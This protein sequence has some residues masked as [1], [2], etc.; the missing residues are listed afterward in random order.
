ML[1]LAPALGAL[2]RRGI[3]RNRGKKKKAEDEAAKTKAASRPM[4]ENLM[5][6]EDGWVVEQEERLRQTKWPA[7]MDT[8]HLYIYI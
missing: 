2:T 1:Q 6:M 5:R 4:R 8:E 3:G 7:T